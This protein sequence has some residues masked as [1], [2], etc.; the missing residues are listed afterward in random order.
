MSDP[1]HGVF[2]PPAMGAH[3]APYPITQRGTITLEDAHLRLNGTRAAGRGLIGLL[4]FGGVIAAFVVMFSIGITDRKIGAAI[5]FVC[6]AIGGSVGATLSNALSRRPL[7]VLIPWSQVKEASLAN[8]E[9]QIIV[10]LGF[11]RKF[12]IHFTVDNAEDVTRVL[13]R[14]RRPKVA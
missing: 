4:G 8:G 3:V 12:M 10:K 13:D 9:L 2:T 7:E 5:V 6:A 14:V 1:I 11:L